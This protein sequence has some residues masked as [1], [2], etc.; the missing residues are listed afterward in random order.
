M[1]I[2]R[3]RAKLDLKRIKQYL[4]KNDVDNETIEEIL[5]KIGVTPNH[6]LQFPKIGR[7]IKTSSKKEMRRILVKEYK[8]FYELKNN[9]IFILKVLHAKEDIKG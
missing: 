9:N 5:N 1:I 4:K 6:L 3:T 2:W 8:I 7:L